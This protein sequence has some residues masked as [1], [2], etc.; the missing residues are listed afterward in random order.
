[1]L[2]RSV[3]T[4]WTFA[5]DRVRVVGGAAYGEEDIDSRD[6]ATGLQT[7]VL[8]PIDVDYQA[9]FGQLEGRPVEL[10]RVRLRVDDAEV[11]VTL[12]DPTF[13]LVLQGDKS[14][15]VA[16]LGSSEPGDLNG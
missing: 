10:P 9:L 12:F 8:E 2:F 16:E 13:P 14:Q 3:Q 1:M 11:A 7:L 4:N 5:E 15:L 6:P